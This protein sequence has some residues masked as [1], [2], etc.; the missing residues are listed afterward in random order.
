ML[1]GQSTATELAPFVNFLRAHAA[2]VRELSSELSRRTGSRSTTTRCSCGSRRAEGSRMRRVDLAQEVLLTPS[3][4]TR[5]LEGLERSGFVER[6]ACKDGPP[7]QLRAVDHRGRGEIARREQDAHRRHPPSLSSTTSTP[8]SASSSVSC[9]DGSPKATTAS[10]ALP[11][12]L[13]AM[14]DLGTMRVK[15]GLAEMLKGG[16][17]MDVVNAEQARDRRRCGRGRGDGAR[18]RPRRHPRAGRRRAHVRP[19]DDPRDPGGRHDPGDGEVPH[20]PLR[21]GADPRGARDRLHRRVRGADARR[22]RAPRRQVEV[23]RAVRLRLRR[24]SARRSGAS[25]RARR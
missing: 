11:S 6:V 15:T 22:P 4:I 2:V 10:L 5:L 1:T 20:R 21:R 18:A 16:V 23:H 9:S 8:A 13:T 17:I 14:L 7:G 3:G 12:K 25:P 19:G 24:T